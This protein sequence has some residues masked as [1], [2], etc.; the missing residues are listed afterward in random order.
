LRRWYETEWEI[1]GGGDREDPLLA[2]VGSGRHL[3]KDEHADEFL[4]GLRGD[5]GDDR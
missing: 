5:W 1:D 2:L 4:A 3:W